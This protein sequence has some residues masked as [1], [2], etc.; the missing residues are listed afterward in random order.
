MPR[1]TRIRRVRRIRGYGIFAEEWYSI[2]SR[3]GLDHSHVCRLCG[4]GTWVS[5]WGRYA[6]HAVFKVCP[7]LWRKFANW[8]L[9]REWKKKPITSL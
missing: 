9:R 1:H 7:W 8:G 5:I 4:M 2:C 3:H 6:S